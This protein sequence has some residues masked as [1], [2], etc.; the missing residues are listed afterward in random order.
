MKK[1]FICL[2]L[3]F[4]LLNMSAQVLTTNIGFASNLSTFVTVDDFTNPNSTRFFPN[5]PGQNL[6]LTTRY[7]NTLFAASTGIASVVTNNT[8]NT[9]FSAIT[10]TGL[11]VMQ[12]IYSNLPMTI[13]PVADVNFRMIVVRPNDNIVR[14][15]I[16]ISNG[17]GDDTRNANYMM[18]DEISDLALRGYVV[19]FFENIVKNKFI[20]QP[21]IW[22]YL[23]FWNTWAPY[24]PWHMTCS[25]QDPLFIMKN[26][27][28]MLQQGI[29]AVHYS[30]FNNITNNNIN[31]DFQIDVANIY[32]VGFSAS[33]FLGNSLGLI[34]ENTNLINNDIRRY[35][36]NST[37]GTLRPIRGLV[38]NPI[39]NFNIRG[40]ASI[41]SGAI[42]NPSQMLMLDNNSNR[43]PVI[44][45]YGKKDTYVDYIYAPDVA[46]YGPKRYKERLDSLQINNKLII[47]CEGD[48]PFWASGGFNAYPLKTATSGRIWLYGQITDMNFFTCDYFNKIRTGI[49]SPNAAN[50]VKTNISNYKPTLFPSSHSGN[51]FLLATNECTPTGTPCANLIPN[52][53]FELTPTGA[54]AFTTDYAP[55][56]TYTFVGGYYI[57][58]IA[59]NIN[60]LWS[61]CQSAAHGKFLIV[62]GFTQPQTNNRIWEKT[63]SGLAPNTNYTFTFETISLYGQN[64]ANLEVSAN[65]TLIKGVQLNANTENCNWTKFKFDFRTAAGV[66]TATI[67]IVDKNYEYMGNDFALDNLFLTNAFCNNA[68][69]RIVNEGKNEVI[70]IQKMLNIS[71]YPSPAS[72]QIIIETFLEENGTSDIQIFDYSGKKIKDIF[73]N[74]T[75]EAGNFRYYEDVSNLPS[76]IYFVRYTFNGTTTTQKFVVNR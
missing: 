33:G 30:I 15:C 43:I 2:F 29:A 76:G 37:T 53:D 66:T 73:T 9:N 58:N 52:G 72:K 24:Y 63:I 46:G 13:T 59:N 48:H 54:N 50:Y 64:Y 74:L 10:N 7:F 31:D 61:G 34:G 44:Q 65:N 71:V 20:N 57:N 6:N 3:T 56:T 11:K 28:Y 23:I 25:P 35:E 19:V 67:K 27:Y 4:C 32:S 49:I 16:F 51:G 75:Q 5:Q 68:N 42:N 45:L 55:I 8:G 1:T 69:S 39:A 17:N 60:P 22:D 40:I 21:S 26:A 47:N 70:T 41:G 18:W 36:C 62:D 38:I 14:P 12:R